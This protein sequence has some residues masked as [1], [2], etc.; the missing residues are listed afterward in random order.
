MLTL[1]LAACTTN[2]DP[3]RIV[4]IPPDDNPMP[5]PAWTPVIPS[6]TPESKTVSVEDLGPEPETVQTRIGNLSVSTARATVRDQIVVTFTTYGG[7][8]WLCGGEFQVPG[9]HSGVGI[10]LYAQPGYG[11]P[12]PPGSLELISYSPQQLTREGASVDATGGGA[13]WNAGPA[14]PKPDNCTTGDRS[15]QG[16]PTGLFG[17]GQTFSATFEVKKP[18]NAW[19]VARVN[20]G[21][22]QGGAYAQMPVLVTSK[23][24][25]PAAVFV[26]EQFGGPFRYEFDGSGSYDIDGEVE[27]YRWD[28]GDG[29]TAEGERVEHLFTAAGEY[30]VTLTVVDDLDAEGSRTNSVELSRLTAVEGR[31]TGASTFTVIVN[32]ELH[33]ASDREIDVSV[34]LTSGFDEEP[35]AT[36]ERTLGD[37]ELGGLQEIGNE[38]KVDFNL[39]EE[40]VPRFV[41]RITTDM[42]VELRERLVDGT[43]F[44]PET[45]TADDEIPLPAVI[46]HGIMG[47]VAHLAYGG[48]GPGMQDLATALTEDEYEEADRNPN[49]PTLKQLTYPSL[50]VGG[51]EYL[52]RNYMQPAVEEMLD[53]TYA[54]KVDIVAHSMGGL[55]SRTY[56]E[57]L[58]GG[59]NVRKLV[60]L[61]TPYEGAAKAHGTLA[62]VEFTAEEGT[63][64]KDAL[65]DLASRIAEFFQ[66]PGAA[67]LGLAAE[68]MPGLES[69]LV[70]QFA[71]QDPS[72]IGITTTMQLLPDYPYY[73]EA[74]SDQVSRGAGYPTDPDMQLQAGILGLL[75]P[76]DFLHALNTGG[77][78]DGVEYFQIYRANHETRLEVIRYQSALGQWAYE[79]VM[80]P[81]D[82]TVPLRSATL[83]DYPELTAQLWKCN[84]PGTEHYLMMGDFLTGLQVR[85]ILLLPTGQDS[86]DG[87]NR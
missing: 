51:I 83:A 3:L 29:E 65:L 43:V 75:G 81:G 54:D 48:I 62:G 14:N 38:V 31:M 33:P 41:E 39:E 61:G 52:A 16:S 50:H 25:D 35:I 40:D 18:I 64:L 72:G 86:V 23:N 45:A 4:G 13:S 56:L 20:T 9:G 63:P 71:L 5:T 24:V 26:G 66:A 12:M 77:F 2:Q 60:T 84:V 28:F 55:V 87:C 78:A 58:G 22:E 7:T 70:D 30:P 21:N 46:T 79:W 34:D 74:D 15:G 73:S 44:D 6:P 67:L 11:Q 42:T 47:D 8:G 57:L 76:N 36:L 53:K 17:D 82:A 19:L 37:D 59:E 68:V 27:E 49:Y 69:Y 32:V 10:N 1:L 85:T 80:G